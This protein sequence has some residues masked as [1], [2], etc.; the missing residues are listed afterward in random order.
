MR[1]PYYDTMQVCTNGDVITDRYE[2]HPE[3]RRD[4][5]ELCGSPT[6]TECPK[7]KTKINGYY[8]S[9]GGAIVVGFESKPPAFCGK[10]G[11]PFPWS[12][13]IKTT[14][15][16]SESKDDLEVLKIIAS[17]FPLVARQLERRHDSRQ[18]LKISDE[19]DVQ[20]VFHSLLQLYF[21]D[22]RPEEWT[23]SYAG[24]A[25]RM[26]FLLKKEQTVAEIKKTKENLRDKEVG[27]ELIIDI[28]RYKKHGDCKKLF[29][30]VYDPDHLIKNPRGVEGDLTGTRDGLKVIVMIVQ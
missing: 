4:H 1:E 22:I 15:S 19:Y 26:D 13:K 16:P 7:C 12:S 21:D 9:G 24:K 20:D 5:C 3:E 6:I 14:A 17:R 30:F 8:H 18:T 25:A 11:Q 27:D 29:C 2:T 23:P 10:C 28:D